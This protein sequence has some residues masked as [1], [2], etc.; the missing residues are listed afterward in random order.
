MSGRRKTWTQS[1]RAHSGPSDE[2]EGVRALTSAELAV[3]YQPIV[4]LATGTLFAV[5]ALARCARPQWAYPPDLFAA[6]E[7]ESAC[8]RLGRMI[9]ELTFERCGAHRV[10]VNI[11]PAELTERW[12]V[13]PDDPLCMH[14]AGVF[15]EITESAALDHFELCNSV[16]RD[17]CAR[18]GAQLVVDDLGAGYSNLLRIVDLEPKVVK[19]DLAI[20]RGLHENKRKQVLVSH[21]VKL[22][23]ELGA[24]VVAEGIETTD[25]LSAVRDTGV[26][27]GQGFLL[28][29]PQ[30]P[31]PKVHWPL[32]RAG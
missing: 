13:R 16:L 4:D 9:R 10:F 2:S 28:A 8:G 1:F 25:E 17:V 3:Q 6:A 20:A 5:E 15:L 19:L 18:T 29:R 22:C 23:N 21:M 32:S 12:L 30:N 24:V 7:R 11:H 14:D 27:L 31:V 26:Q